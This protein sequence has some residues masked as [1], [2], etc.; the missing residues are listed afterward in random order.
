VSHHIARLEEEVGTPLVTR[1]GRGV[2]LT[3]AGAALAAHADELLARL[4]AAEE[5]VAAIAGLRAGHVRLAAFPSATATLVPPAL[6]ALRAA[7]PG[8]TVSLVEHEPPEALAALRAGDLD[9]AV[10]FAYPEERDD[11]ERGIDRVA[12][13]SEPLLA[14]LPRGDRRARAKAVRLED[15]AEDTWIAG[16]ERCRTHLLAGCA[17]AGFE[18]RIAFATDDYVA[19]QSLVAAGMGVALLPTLAV[20]HV[21]RSDVAIRALTSDD[22][23]EVFA[24]LPRADRHPPAVAAMLAALVGAT[25]TLS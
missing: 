4:A 10:A 8:V 25:S 11:D 19:V 22:H 1:D 17:A 5:D 7:H 21:K 2:R 12:L 14:V 16:C 13:I 3:E 9:L 6:A 20:H 23:R 24:A 15:L 18:P